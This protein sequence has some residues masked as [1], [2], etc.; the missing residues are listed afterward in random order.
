MEVTIVYANLLNK[1][2]IK[3]FEFY[4]YDH[5]LNIIIKTRILLCLK[6]KNS[7]TIVGYN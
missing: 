4:I 5:L 3:N 2:N 6:T 1:I 7:Q